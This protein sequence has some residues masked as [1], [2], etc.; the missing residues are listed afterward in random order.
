MMVRVAGGRVRVAQACD[1]I[2]HAWNEFRDNAANNS[3]SPQQWA[4]AV[5]RMTA[6]FQQ[7]P[8]QGDEGFVLDLDK[9]PN[10]DK[11]NMIAAEEDE[12]ITDPRYLMDYRRLWDQ[13]N[14][15]IE[16]L[17]IL[18]SSLSSRENRLREVII[19]QQIDVRPPPLIEDGT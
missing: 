18:D 1:R 14:T 13:R 7:L 5:N 15:A 10:F 11:N 2:C 4:V 19:D 12:R 3:A 16:A 9:H 17:N 6:A 8:F